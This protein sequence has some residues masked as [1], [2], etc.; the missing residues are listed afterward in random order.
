MFVDQKNSYAELASF[1][2]FRLARTQ[3][4]LNAQATALLKARSDLSLVE[5]RIILL[6]RLYDDASMSKIAAD[7]QMDKGQL[8]RKVAA[9]TKKGLIQTTPD[10]HDNRMLHLHLTPKALALAETMT[11]VM[12]K[13]QEFLVKGVDP[14]EL[15]VFL[16][17][18]ARI[19][20]AAETRELD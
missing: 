15:E 16:N 7:V 10:D 13:R 14:D 6:V 1:L 11:P 4:K 19:D 20:V 3:N 17:V 12:R 18:L 9:M 2:T 8:S 5:W